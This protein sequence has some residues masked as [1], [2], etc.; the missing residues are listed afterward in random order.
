MGAPEQFKGLSSQSLS[1]FRTES[2]TL[3][4][5]IG[6]N[7]ITAVSIYRPPSIPLSTWSHELCAPFEAAS[8]L[9][10][11]VF[12]AGDFNA[13]LL[14]PDK[15]PKDGRK[16]LDLLDIYDLCC[17]INEATRKTK[18]SET[19]LDL[20]LTNNKRTT[21]TSGVVDTLISDHSLVYTVL[22]SSAPRLRSRRIFSRNFKTFSKQNFVRD[23]QM[24]PFHV[25]DLFDEVDDK[26][27]TFEQLYLDILDEHAPLK[28]L[29]IRGKQVPYMNEEWRKAIR[30]RN[31]LW[32][33]FTRHRT[34]ENYEKY[35]CQRNKC[36]SLRRKAI[37]NYF[38]RKSSQP[39]N[40][41]DFWSAY[42]PFLNSKAKQA[43]DIFLKENDAVISDK[44]EIAD[45]F[46]NYFAQIAD[47]AQ[48]PSK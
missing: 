5:K 23:T 32:R 26:L 12:Y 13:D 4:V 43:N 34:D 27:Y 39:D 37:R 38:R 36:T 46:N 19:L 2:L 33:I 42:R 29:H 40:P 15:P 7:W 30:H 6:K 1:N 9:T 3:K 44:K 48:C 47:C 11:T 41:R 17:L 21:L 24:A 10:N 31:R 16:L 45:L 20:I 14:A 22:R 18:T 8:T 25:M 28:R 35:K